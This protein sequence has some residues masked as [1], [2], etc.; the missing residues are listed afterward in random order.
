MEAWT[1]ASDDRD[2]E[3]AHNLDEYMEIEDK[4]SE[5][6][7]GRAQTT[8]YPAKD[9]VTHLDVQRMI[10]T[11]VEKSISNCNAPVLTELVKDTLIEM[12]QV[13]YD[14]TQEVVNSPLFILMGEVIVDMIQ[15]GKVDSLLMRNIGA[16][17]QSDWIMASPTRQ[18]A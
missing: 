8:E 9:F 16:L 17:T 13:V 18:V 3:D 14:G 12:L 2:G 1:Q 10:A 11:E 6:H 5:F 15:K 4:E 7:R